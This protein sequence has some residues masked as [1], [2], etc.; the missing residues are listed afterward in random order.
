LKFTPLVHRLL[1]YTVVNAK[2]HLFPLQIL[3]NGTNFDKPTKRFVHYPLFIFKK[4]QRYF[5]KS[6]QQQSTFF[7]GPKKK[8]NKKKRTNLK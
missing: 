5:W 2:G 8:T 3:P 6:N 7:F 1:L 4:Q